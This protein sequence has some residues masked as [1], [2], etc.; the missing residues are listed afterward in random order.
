MATDR[1]FK[2]LEAK[3]AEETPKRVTEAQAPGIDPSQRGAAWAYLT[4]DQPIPNFT[5]RFLRGLK[6]KLKKRRFWE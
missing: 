1:L 3:I 6:R 5:E 2:E 4:T